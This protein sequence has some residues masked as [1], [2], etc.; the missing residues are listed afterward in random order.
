MNAHPQDLAEENRVLRQRVA[1]LERALESHVDPILQALVRHAPGYLNVVTVEGRVLATGR[2]NEAF[3]SVVGRSVFEFSEPESHAV[4]RRAFEQAARTGR[5]VV[6][7]QRGQ[8][9]NGEPG[10]SY[11]VRT[12]PL[13]EDTGVAALLLVPTD[14]TE[15]VRLEQ[16]LVESE[17]ALR[18]AVQASHMGLWS[19]DIER[20]RVEWDARVHEIFGMHETPVTFEAF[21]QLVHPDDRGP[22]EGIVRRAFETGVL[23]TLE[24]RLHSPPDS[25]ERWVLEAATVIHDESGKPSR[26]MGGVLDISEQKRLAAQQKRAERVEAVGHLTAGLAHNF[27]NLLAAILPNLEVALRTAT[28]NDRAALTAAL[29]ASLQARDLVK[30]LLALA[31]RPSAHAADPCAPDDVVRRV[32]SICRTTFPREIDLVA[33]VDPGV[34]LVTMPATDLEQVL[35]NLLL[36]ARDAVELAR[37]P[38]RRVQ[39]I[40]DRTPLGDA[41]RPVRIRVVDTGVGMT[42]AVR[43]RVFEP[44]F[45]TKPPHL[46]SGLGLSNALARVRESNGVLDCESA[47]G[48]GTTFT[49]LLQEP[50]EARHASAP[51][52]APASTPRGETILV[53]DDEPL[54]RLGIRRILEMERYEVLEAD[55]AEAARAVLDRDGS[56]VALIILD[57]SMPGETGIDAL[58]SLRERCGAPVILFT[59]L[60]PELPGDIAALLDKPARH[61]E[62]I[63][64]VREILDRTGPRS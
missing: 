21:M 48:V 64:L 26:I 30:S 13:S 55:S 41:A 9:E 60:A 33:A 56:R 46:G 14:I 39:L 11:L 20:N 47:P 61:A 59:G 36:N 3:G 32:E 50:G 51:E 29:D 43:R 15:R 12:I 6:Y 19:W 34:G 24:Y 40:L 62:V 8:G 17:R 22:I 58:A 44:F 57:H 28:G 37:G 35:L 2:T 5:P 52:A 23:P 53:V 45:T 4:M 42:E 1:E 54:V 27:N 63:R 10:H 25:P 38:V 49:L 31:R 7:E 16:S 18:L